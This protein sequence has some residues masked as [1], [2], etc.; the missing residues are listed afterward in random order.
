[1]IA[2]RQRKKFLLKTQF[3]EVG[4]IWDT[5][6][7]VLSQPLWTQNVV[8]NVSPVS[9]IRWKLMTW[10]WALRLWQTSSWR[11]ITLSCQIRGKGTTKNIRT[12]ERIVKICI[13][14]LSLRNRNNYNQCPLVIILFY[15]IMSLILFYL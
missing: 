2:L 13:Q 9:D 7:E 11:F 1:M 12:A 3:R 14:N 10:H 6:I 8:R 4:R 5:S 15:F